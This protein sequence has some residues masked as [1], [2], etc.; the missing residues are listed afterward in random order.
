MVGENSPSRK[1]HRSKVI[2]YM[3]DGLPEEEAIERADK[4]LLEWSKPLPLPDAP[5]DAWI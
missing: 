2:E 5:A 3:V 4:N 1:F